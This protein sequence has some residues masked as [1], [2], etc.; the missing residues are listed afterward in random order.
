MRAHRLSIVLWALVAVAPAAAGLGQVITIDHDDTDLTALS[1]ASINK[2]KSL[3]HIAY[4]HTSHGS[5]VTD[6][7]TGLVDFVNGGGLGLTHP[8]DLFAWNNGG[9][10]G[11]LDL[12][13]RFRSGDL[14]NPDRTTWAV[15]TRDYLGEAAN[16][17]V[18]VIMW[19][20]CGQADTSAAN[21][22]L[23]LSTMSLLEADYP[24]VCFVYMTG[25]VNGC[26]T[27]ENLFLRNQ[28][29]RDYCTAG[30]KIL[31]D[32]ADIESYDPDGAYYGD[33]R[34]TDDCWYDS[35]G[36]GSRDRNWAADWQGSH[37]ED[38]D[39]Y[40]CSAA[41]SYPLNGNRKAYAAWTLWTEIAARIAPPSP[42]D[43]D[44][45]GDVDFD[46]YCTVRDAF[47]GT[48]MEWGDGDCD[49]DGVLGVAD[50]LALKIAYTSVGADA[51]LPEPA[52]L[53]LLAP[54]GLALLLRRRVN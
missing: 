8:D 44:Q 28:Q 47:G 37:V 3:L 50:Y 6:G 24:D 7:M 34:V 16:G 29:I 42:G 52:T 46:D 19:S 5:Q 35:D 23:Y 11:A 39:W 22:S 21:I 25:H 33:K 12:H 27:T 40:S 31:Y 15:R 32:F 45:D 26:A 13:D 51:T 36:N 4:G 49:G 1:E 2:A 17:D 41:H 38:V 53:S 43:T 10:G 9:A 30:G 54:A 20:W 14:G 48:G 18:N